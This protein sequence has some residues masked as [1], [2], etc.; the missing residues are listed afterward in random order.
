MVQKLRNIWLVLHSIAWEL[1]TKRVKS[2]EPQIAARAPC[3]VF[4]PWVRWERGQVGIW[5][6]VRRRRLEI[7]ECFMADVQGKMLTAKC[8]RSLNWNKRCYWKFGHR[9]L[10]LY[11][12]ASFF[13]AHNI[14][15]N[16]LP[17]NKDLF[18]GN[19]E[20][21]IYGF[22]DF[23][24]SKIMDLDLKWVHVARYELILIRMEPY[25]SG[26]F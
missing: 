15:N 11:G 20:V 2:S 9:R 17:A 14:R 22:R 8:S 1:D 6:L 10:R 7:W 21:K 18:S 16:G 13:E 23:I 19:L 4:D 5:E 24:C 25:G 3:D 12:S 26:S